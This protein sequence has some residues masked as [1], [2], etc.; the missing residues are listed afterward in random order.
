M[1]KK[2]YL[3]MRINA[4]FSPEEKAEH[5]EA[6]IRFMLRANDPDK[7]NV[8]DRHFAELAHDT[9]V[10]SK[11]TNIGVTEDTLINLAREMAKMQQ[12]IQRLS[13][14]NQQLTKSA[15]A[16]QNDGNNSQFSP[17]MF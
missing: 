9:G 14:E 10:E 15:S 16:N 5:L 3:F 12:E 6:R 4:K 1:L 7:Q 8:L 17:R 13:H 2:Y 11:V